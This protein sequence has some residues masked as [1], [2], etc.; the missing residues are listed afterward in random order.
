[1]FFFRKRVI[2]TK[3]L[4]T[5]G[6]LSVLCETNISFWWNRSS[7]NY[8]YVVYISY[9]FM[10]WLGGQ[11]RLW[12]VFISIDF[13]SASLGSTSLCSNHLFNNKCFMGAKSRSIFTSDWFRTSRTYNFMFTILHRG[14]RTLFAKHSPEYLDNNKQLVCC[15]LVRCATFFNHRTARYHVWLHQIPPQNWGLYLTTLESCDSAF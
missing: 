5:T 13:W 7:D 8:T 3:L 9:I 12:Q 1:M 4:K 14:W 15:V 11:Q 2:R 10:M 6:L